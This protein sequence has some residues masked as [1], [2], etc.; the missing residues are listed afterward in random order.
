MPVSTLISF[1][2]VALATFY[3]LHPEFN[4]AT[5]ANEM[6][7]SLQRDLLTKFFPAVI[8]EEKGGFLTTFTYDWKLTGPQDKMIVT[9]ARHTWTPAKAALFYPGNQEYRTAARH[10]YAYLRNVLWDKYHGGFYTWVSRDG[11]PKDDEPKTAYGNAFGIY[12]LAAYYQ[13][14]GDTATLN[15]AKQAFL[16]LEKHSHDPKAKGYFQHLTREGKPILKRSA[17]N[18]EVGYKDQNSSIH[19]LEAFTELYS[20]WPDNLLRVRLQEM[21]M[22]IRDRIVTPKGYLT[23][24]LTPEWKPVSY[25]DSSETARKA[26]HRLDHVS[27]GHDVETAYLLLE[28]SHTLGLKHDEVTMKIAKKMVDHALQNGWDNQAGGFYDQGYYYK[29]SDKIAIIHDA[30]NWWTQ[31]EALNTLLLMADTYPNDKQQYYDKFTKQWEYVKKY[32]LDSKY[33]GWYAGGIDKEPDQAKGN[34]G[35]AWKACYHESRSL[36]NCL[37]RLN[38]DKQAP[39]AP[40][41]LTISTNNSQAVVKWKASTDN[42]QVIG[43]DIYLGGKKIGFTPLA[44]FALSASDASKKNDLYVIAKDLSGNETVSQAIT[45]E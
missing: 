28:A 20:V 39:S 30:K 22:L 6:E 1:L 44:Q 43:Y 17:T 42:R 9:Q 31:A 25:R 13:L 26:N 45:R 36:M 24:F 15:L 8:D 3:P 7:Q 41:G 4:R 37:L 32:L 11:K 29:G 14:S 2:L 5:I 19:L 35:H 33:G 38:P 10:G 16:W 34:K 40:T 23:L 21:L 18:P 27:F 12:A